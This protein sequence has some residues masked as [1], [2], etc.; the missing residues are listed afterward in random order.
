MKDTS[1]IDQSLK[2]K[3][4]PTQA[5]LTNIRIYLALFFAI[6]LIGITNPPIEVHAWRQAFTNTIARNFLEIDNNILYP[7][8]NSSGIREGVVASEFPIF[9]YLIY[10]VSTVFGHQHW[11]GR[12][13]NL[14]F[15]TLGIYF[16]YRIIQQIWNRQFAFCA[17]LI[18]QMSIWFTYARKVMPDTFSIALM[19]GAIFFALQYLD[20]GKIW[21][22][23]TFGILASLGG[24]SK[25]P[26]TVLLSLLGIAFISP[27]FTLQRRGYVLGTTAISISI[28]A[29][30]YFVWDPHLLATY[31]NQLYYPRS[32][33]EGAKEIIGMWQLSLKQFYFYGL[34]SYVGFAFFLLGIMA[35]FKQKDKL[36]VAIFGLGTLVFLFFIAKT[37]KVFS[38]HT[39]YMIPYV[40]LMAL[41]AAYGMYTFVPKKWLYLALGAVVIEGFA[42]QQHELRL[43]KENLHLLTL[44]KEIV[45]HH[46]SQDAKIVVSGGLN[47]MVMYFAHRNGWS[48]DNYELLDPNY[49]Q[50]CSREGAEYVLV[51]HK[52]FSETLPLPILHQ[53][54]FFTLYQ[55]SPQRH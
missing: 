20:K 25:I 55:M 16:F 38:L 14:I 29:F 3:V 51:Y 32:L 7:R 37:G 17:A 28:I 50:K 44:E 41:M 40:P 33:V 35:L 26:A 4:P 52:Q 43:K 42:N 27:Q 9:N 11:Y 30:W 54:Q 36:M 10:M 34:R 48:V 8:I 13:I 23:L 45:D 47:P 12:L 2:N 18:L 31:G 24:L 21:R 1:F 5:I 15:S 46:I 39:Y 53:D 6:A 49:L 22:L 19:L